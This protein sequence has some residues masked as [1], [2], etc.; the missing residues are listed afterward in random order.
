MKN[1][2]YG[3]VFPLATFVYSTVRACLQ[4]KAI[5]KKYA[6]LKKSIC[7]KPSTS[8]TLLHTKNYCHFKTVSLQSL[9]RPYKKSTVYAYLITQEQFCNFFYFFLPRFNVERAKFYS[10]EIVCALKFL[11]KKGIVYRYS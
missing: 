10:A 9:L 3:K 1:K 2:E 11:H 7:R 4:E 6:L 8:F 5:S